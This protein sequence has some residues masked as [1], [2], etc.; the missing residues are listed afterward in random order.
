M[1][2]IISS[3]SKYGTALRAQDFND[4]TVLTMY[5][6]SSED[7]CGSSGLLGD[8]PPYKELCAQLSL[9]SNASNVSGAQLRFSRGG[10]QRS[11]AKGGS[12]KGTPS[13]MRYFS[14]AMPRSGPANVC[15]S[16]GSVTLS[17]AV[18]GQ[19]PDGG[20]TTPE[21]GHT[22]GGDACGLHGTGGGAVQG[23]A[24]AVWSSAAAKASSVR[25]PIRLPYERPTQSR[26]SQQASCV[27]EYSYGSSTVAALERATASLHRAPTRRAAIDACISTIIYILYACRGPAAAR[28][29]AVATAVHTGHTLTAS[30]RIP[31]LGRLRAPVG[32]GESTGLPPWWIALISLWWISM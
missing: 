4:C 27:Y 13:H 7:P 2:K 16:V 8:H 9:L 26:P 6:Q 5:R 11:S 3:S 28:A 10:I 30:S 31:V 22:S 21:T 19:K 17:A 18:L 24:L 12:A 23:T 29:R 1:P 20:Q 32:G 15:T 14:P 25:V